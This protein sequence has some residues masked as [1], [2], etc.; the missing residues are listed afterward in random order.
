M[1]VLENLYKNN[2][3]KLVVIGVSYDNLSAN[4]IEEV[5]QKYQLTYPMVP[6]LASKKFSSL[7]FRVLP[8]TL[9]INPEGKWVKTLKG[10]QTETQLAT[11][12]G[13]NPRN[14]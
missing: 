10:P 9:I 11:A 12:M 6:N 2:Q 13:I 14:G 1:P 5:R 7:E 8:L 3:N 4:E